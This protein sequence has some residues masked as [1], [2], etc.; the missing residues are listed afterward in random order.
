MFGATAFANRLHGAI[1]NVT[2]GGGPGNFPGVGFVGAGGIY[3]QRQN[4]DAIDARGL[5]A[6]LEWRRG[7]WN[8]RAAASLTHARLDVRGA[9]APLDRLRPAQTPAFAS[10]LS[11]GYERAGRGGQLTIR[12]IG[13]QYEDDLN[14]RKL[15]GATT[16]DAS[17]FWPVTRR[18]QLVA[19]GENLFNKLVMA[20]IGSDGSIERA[21]PRTLWIGLRLRP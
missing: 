21:M 9:A 20:G 2:I 6:S 10:T 16:V 5:E 4:V 12:S 8:A 13:N 11:A 17:A 7:P 18:V 15:K 1:S 3:R 14:S 19:R